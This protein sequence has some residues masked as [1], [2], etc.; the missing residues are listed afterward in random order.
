MTFRYTTFQHLFFMT[1]PCGEEMFSTTHFTP[2]DVNGD[3]KVF[4]LIRIVRS[5]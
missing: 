4:L 3:A 1:K 5:Y 2:N